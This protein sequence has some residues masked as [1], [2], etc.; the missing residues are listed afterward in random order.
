MKK[1]P[2]LDGL[3][4]IAIALVIACHYE[5]FAR[6]LWGLPKFGWV[7]VDLFF[8]LSGFL[9]TSVLLNLHGK[10]K[11][12]ETF[13]ARRFRR[14]LPPYL[15][16]ALLIYLVTAA[17]HDYALFRLKSVVGFVFFL[18]SFGRLG[19]LLHQIGTGNALH[20]QHTPMAIMKSGMS[21]NVSEARD[22]LW[23]LSIEEYFYLLWAPFVIWL[24]RRW[25]VTAAATI[26]MLAFVLRWVGFIGVESYFSIFHRFDAPV[27]GALVALL[28][29]SSLS[30]RTVNF[31]LV[32]SG[33]V[34][35]VTLLAVLAPMGNFL[36]ME[37]RDD[38]VFGVFG[39]PA[40][41]LTAASVVGLAVTNAGAPALVVLRSSVLGFLGKISYTLYLLHG[42][43]YLVF[44]RF[45]R[46]ESTVSI[47][48]LFGAIA[49]SWLSWTYL[50]R[51][52]LSQSLASPQDVRSTQLSFSSNTLKNPRASAPLHTKSEKQII[53]EAKAVQAGIGQ[54]NLNPCDSRFCP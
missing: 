44:L 35:V 46:L 40:L 4:G 47:A 7:G 20:L 29:N 25:L 2:E 18:Q 23:S 39:I 11:P 53:T 50:E 34:G 8:V 31:V 6:Q 54:S 38:H 36:N 27:C 3:R 30:R 17:L 51:P 14:I 10:P 45:F 13:Y 28:I 41:S 49:L 5:V 16:F 42:L 52:I 1:I 32:V 12:F 48:A 15:A 43:V 33:V 26:C 37:I 22:V 24:S 19:A 9:I 21:G